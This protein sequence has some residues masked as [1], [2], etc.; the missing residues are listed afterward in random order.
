MLVKQICKHFGPLHTAKI[1]KIVMPEECAV[2][3]HDKT[4]R[5]KTQP[6]KL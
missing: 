3:T 2:N 5:E 6:S 4:V 1:S